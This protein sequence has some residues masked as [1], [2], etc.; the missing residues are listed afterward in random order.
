M[1]LTTK[2]WAEEWGGHKDRTA[3]SLVRL[4][5][6]CCALTF[7]PFTDPVSSKI[8]QKFALLAV[9]DGCNGFLS[10]TARCSLG[11]A[12]YGFLNG[13]V[14]GGWPPHHIISKM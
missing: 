11:R 7:R 2:E 5:F 10:N 8:S 3:E 1:Y 6:Y 14:K 13:G 9:T 12:L 4:P